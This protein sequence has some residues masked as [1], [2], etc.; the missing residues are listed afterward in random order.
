MSEAVW[1]WREGSSEQQGP[2]TWEKLQAMAVSGKISPSDWVMREGW[3]D[4]K[5]ACEANDSSI[6]AA[7]VGRPPD[8]L[9]LPLPPLPQ[10]IPSAPAVPSLPMQAAMAPAGAGLGMPIVM[11]PVSELG[12]AALPLPLPPLA[13]QQT[14]VDIGPPTA[15]PDGVNPGEVLQ[16]RRVLRDDPLPPED[17][18]PQWNLPAVAALV[19]SC[20]GLMFLAFEM[21]LIGAGLGVWCL[22]ASSGGGNSSGKKLAMT[23]VLIGAAD[24]VFRVLCATVDLGLVTQ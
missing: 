4:W 8:P 12:S 22:Y 17:G 14:L 13:P 3:A 2:V 9:P 5:L 7:A 1:Y 11:A 16:L 20:A 15:G 18:S 10:Q 21:G 19:A 6:D 24:V 23:A